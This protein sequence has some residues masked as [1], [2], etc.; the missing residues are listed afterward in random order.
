[1]LNYSITVLWDMENMKETLGLFDEWF[2]LP[3]TR[4]RIRNVTLLRSFAS[5]VKTGCRNDF[6]WFLKTFKVRATSVIMKKPNWFKQDTR[7]LS[8]AYPLNLTTLFRSFGF[9]S[10]MLLAFCQAVK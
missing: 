5:P 4:R 2:L 9:F 6:P 3:P 1:M 7:V 8:S 10:R